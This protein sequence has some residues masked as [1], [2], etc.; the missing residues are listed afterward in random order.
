MLDFKELPKDGVRFEQ[1]IREILMKKRLSPRW[2]GQG[3][4]SGRDLLVQEPLSGA[5]QDSERLW[6]VDC[7][8]KAHSNT[9]VGVKDVMDIRDRCARVGAQGLL[10]ACSTA[11]SSEPSRKLEELRTK[12]STRDRSLGCGDDRTLA[13][14]ARLLFHRPAVLS[15]LIGRAG[16]EAVLHGKRAPM[17]RAFQGIFFLC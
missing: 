16:L 12:T 8:H 13:P 6:L 7:K 2:T 17:D 5:I 4:D 15:T 3:A 14:D 9:A 1:L 11:M 10:I